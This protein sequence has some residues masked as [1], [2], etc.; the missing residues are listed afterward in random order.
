MSADLFAEFGHKPST[1][2]PSSTPSQQQAIASQTGSLIPDFDTVDQPTTSRFSRPLN[3]PTPLYTRQRA[4][5]NHPTHF[6]FNDFG[7]FQQ[8]QSGNGNDVLFDAT[9]ESFPDDSSDD[10]GEFE[11]AEVPP[12]QSQT[13]PPVGHEIKNGDVVLETS[14]S[15]KPPRSAK[16]IPNLLDSW[17]TLSID[18]KPQ[19][20]NRLPTNTLID[21]DPMIGSHAF[22]S[23]RPRPTL[24][25]EEEPFEEWGDFTDGPMEASQPSYLSA[26]ASH[27]SAKP[28]QAAKGAPKPG[29][30]TTQAPKPFTQ[31]PLASHVRPTN[32]PPPSI[33]LELFPQLF[34]RL[35]REGT[36]ARKKAQQKENLDAVA[37]SILCTL[38]TA[39]RVVAGRTLRWKRD[40]ILSQS[41]RIGPA[42]SGKAGGMKLSTVNKNEDLKEQQEAIDVINMWRDRASLFNSIIQAAGKRPVQ[43]ILENTRVTTATAGQGAIKASHA[44]AL[45]GLKRDERIPKLDENVEDSFGEWWT[46]HWGHTGCR[47]FWEDN[48]GF[49]GQR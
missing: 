31:S 5:N 14:Q 42:R 44:C 19:P 7:D 49:L 26:S 37:L 3:E 36:E 18:D 40:A 10:W 39:S 17:E 25:M 29:E 4:A 38:K 32:I 45:C 41:M 9:L 34:E 12:S 21:D 35:Q 27:K 8:S 22:E 33:L 43:V 16:A 15:S 13:K 2:Q 11:T 47:L 28:A 46:E 20:S 6:D 23:Q 24:P 48:M 1:S 30:R